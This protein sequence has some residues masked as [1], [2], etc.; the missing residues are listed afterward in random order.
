MRTKNRTVIYLRT[1][2]LTSS[3]EGKDSRIRQENICR[4]FCNRENL[5]VAEIFYDQGVSGSSS[6]LDRFQFKRMYLYCIENDIRNIVFENNTRFS[7]DLIEQ[8]SAFNFLE[9]EEF[10]LFSAT[11]GQWNKDESSQDLVRKI[12][13]AVAEYERKQIVFRLAVARD[14]KRIDNQKIGLTTING[15]G[16]VGGAKSHTELDQELVKLAKRLRRRNWKT[17]KQLSYRKIADKMAKEYGKLNRNGTV[18]SASSVR[19]MCNQ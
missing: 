8:E 1:S 9:K 13:A 14:R 19:S 10:I 15:R 3:A 11:E 12:M 4:D 5:E 2:S 17:K 18:Y 16:K 7:R 6:V